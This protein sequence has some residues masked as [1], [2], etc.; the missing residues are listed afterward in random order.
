MTL[1]PLRSFSLGDGQEDAGLK[2][3][4]AGTGFWISAH[5]WKSVT[6]C[7]HWLMVPLP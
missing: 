1:G 7:S 5:A 4:A 6:C 3:R 2:Y